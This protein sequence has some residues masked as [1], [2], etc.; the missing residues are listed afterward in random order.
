[1]PAARLRTPMLAPRL[2]TGAN[3]K[4][5][6]HVSALEPTA[7]AVYNQINSCRL[8]QEFTGGTMMESIL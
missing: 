7:P 8:H 1:M 4:R 3:P 2:R 6:L 5:W